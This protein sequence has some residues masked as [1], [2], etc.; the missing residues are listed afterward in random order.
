MHVQT[1]LFPSDVCFC[2]LK[3][4]AFPSAFSKGEMFVV[5]RISCC[6]CN[7]LNR[8]CFRA[9]WPAK[10]SSPPSSSILTHLYSGLQGCRSSWQ[11]CAGCAGEGIK[12]T[13]FCEQGNRNPDL[14][15]WAYTNCPS[16]EDEDFSRRTKYLSFLKG[17]KVFL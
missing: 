12:G 7:A 13:D 8:G 16:K 5:G 4:A 2:S 1:H 9:Q 15:A 3:R 11:C 14:N 17:T 6:L 10:P